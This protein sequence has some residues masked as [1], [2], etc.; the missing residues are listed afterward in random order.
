VIDSVLRCFVLRSMHCGSSTYHLNNSRAGVI[1]LVFII[2]VFI[3]VFL[4]VFGSVF[5]SPSA[6]RYLRLS[7]LPNR[8]L[9]LNES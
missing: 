6:I 1:I 4:S 8:M 7:F 3:S 5:I 2:S 9:L